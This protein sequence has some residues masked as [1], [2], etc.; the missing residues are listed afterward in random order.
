MTFRCSYLVF[1]REVL[2]DW[3][4]KSN[5]S[6]AR[7]PNP[8]EASVPHTLTTHFRTLLRN[9]QP[10]EDRLELAQTLPQR[11][12]DFL[13]LHKDFVTVSPHTRLAG[14]YAQFLTVGDVKDVDF[15]VRGDGDPEND[16]PTARVVLTSLAEALRE[17]PDYLDYTGEAYFDITRNRRSVQVKFENEEFF[18]DVVPS[19]APD[20]FDEPLFVPD[21]GY[22]SWIASHPLGVVQLVE[23][24]EKEN[25][26]KFRSHCKL[27]KQFRNHN[28]KYMRPKS[29]WLVSLTIEAVKSG[30]VKT[31]ATLAE[32]FDQLINWIF[33]KFE[34]YLDTEAVP[35]IA[36]PMLGHNVAHNWD[37]HAF[38]FFMDCLDV[39]RG[40]SNRALEATDKAKAIA[41]WQDIF[42]EDF[43][44]DV[45][46]SARD[47]AQ[48]WNP[49]VSHVA[50]NGLIL[51]SQVPDQRSV[52]LRETKFYGAEGE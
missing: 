2:Y 37:R 7:S 22:E 19:I 45:E 3:R 44:T 4:S 14:S 28:M 31:T 36:D 10:P 47:M 26:G 52:P 8:K 23:D 49:R 6:S 1:S 16:A 33:G 20:G 27:L 11:V 18:L 34:S 43:P 48:L 38:L 17:L 5:I 42:G 24:L 40:R 50:A 12:R 29:Y 9:I 41:L 51:A 32:G 25:P 46:E 15:L 21:W 13:R 35:E 30:K 39:A